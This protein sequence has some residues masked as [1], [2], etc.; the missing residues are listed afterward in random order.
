LCEDSSLIAD[1]FVNHFQNTFSFNGAVC[2]IGAALVLRQPVYIFSYL[3]SYCNR[4]AT[5]RAQWHSL[6]AA[7]SLRNIR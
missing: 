2:L 5:C 3:L 7:A 4:L 6:T 1:K